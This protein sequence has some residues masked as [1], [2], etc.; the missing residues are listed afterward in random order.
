MC[1]ANGYLTERGSVVLYVALLIGEL[2]LPAGVIL[3]SDSNPFFSCLTLMLYTTLF[4]KLISYAHVNH[5]RRN[6]LLNAAASEKNKDSLASVS[7][8]SSNKVTNVY[9]CK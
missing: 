2:A 6:A 3:L 4:L 8:T 5:W 9:W 1:S 7:T